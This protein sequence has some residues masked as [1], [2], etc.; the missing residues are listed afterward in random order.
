MP[1]SAQH[2]AL[3]LKLNHLQ[4]QVPPTRV[5]S[6]PAP[7][8]P[9]QRYSDLA[10]E[11]AKQ[12]AGRPAQASSARE[13]A[14]RPASPSRVSLKSLFD[15]PTLIV[16]LVATGL[17]VGSALATML[18]TDA[19]GTPWSEPA[20]PLPDQTSAPAVLSA[21]AAGTSVPAPAP[22]MPAPGQQAAPA[23]QPMQVAA[24]PPQESTLP[25]EVETAAPEDGAGLFGDV[26]DVYRPD[27]QS[28]VGFG[29]VYDAPNSGAPATRIPEGATRSPVEQDAAVG[30]AVPLAAADAAG[31][32]WIELPV[33]VNLRRGPST[34]AGVIG[35]MEKG[36]KL[37]ELERQRGWVKV[38]DPETQETGWLYP[39]STPKRRAAKQP[40]AK[41]SEP[42]SPG[43]FARL[44]G[45]L[46]KPAAP[47]PPLPLR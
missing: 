39:N 29:A 34:K 7:T 20:A 22:A 13:P 28:G 18:L 25:E 14:P 23:D 9:D 35:V 46:G 19:I 16:C 33:S 45:L 44:E 2:H 5:V 17:L 26:R 12:M 6:Q 1:A 37:Q 21:S 10:A 30:A 43:P 15:F 40:A 8:P 36:R 24:L 38:I 3:K 47:S 31:E 32:K 41:A 42:A 27:G 11:I 4:Y